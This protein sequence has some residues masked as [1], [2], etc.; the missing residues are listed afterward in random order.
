MALT[1]LMALTFSQS[2]LSEGGGIV[3]DDASSLYS[4]PS[5]RFILFYVSEISQF[6]NVKFLLNK[7]KSDKKKK[8]YSPFLIF[9]LLA[10][11]A[12]FHLFCL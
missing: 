10:I 7:R 11:T 6:S 3:T 2:V 12:S 4:A 8:S 1:T 9:V 5:G